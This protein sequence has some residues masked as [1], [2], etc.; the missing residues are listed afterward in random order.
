MHKNYLILAGILIIGLLIASCNSNTSNPVN[1]PPADVGSIYVQSTP[2]GAQIWV[3]GNNSTKTTPDSV[4]N[5]SAG[6]H[7]VTLKLLGYLDDID[8]ITVQ[9]GL[10]TQLQRNL[11]QD[12]RILFDS[13]KIWE[14]GG[15]SAAQPSGIILKSGTA[16][17]I[18]S[19]SNTGVDIYYSTGGGLV[20]ASMF[21]INQRPTSFLVSAGTNIA[22]RVASPLYSTSWVT[23]ISDQTNTYFYLYD[24]DHHYSKM[25]ITSRGNDGHKWLIVKWYYNIN[26]F[27]IRF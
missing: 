27:D 17:S 5:L 1:N 26:A 15:T 21:D 14:S 16:S 18:L 3:D 12:Y 22:D 23:Q 8:T 13:I 7:A 9:G 4:T 2:A 25:I 19:G 20:L 11:V 24:N 6:N 10:Q